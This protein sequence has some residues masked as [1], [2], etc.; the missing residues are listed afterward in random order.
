[1]GQYVFQDMFLGHFP[2]FLYSLG[3]YGVLYLYLP[4]KLFLTSNILVLALNIIDA[5]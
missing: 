1:M 2:V 4:L 5:S 3:I